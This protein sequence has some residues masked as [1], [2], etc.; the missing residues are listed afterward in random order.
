MLDVLL[1]QDSKSGISI[2]EYHEKDT[3]FNKDHS[4]IFS[5]FLMAIQS[6]TKELN[7]GTVVLIS[8]EGIRGHNCIIIPKSVINIILL[9]DQ[10]D[11]INVWRE[12]GNLIAER[13]LEMYGEDLKPY[14]ISMYKDFKKTIKE[15]CMGHKYCS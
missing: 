4:D 3:K 13:F 14:N 6:I 12:Q 7:I 15:L 8:T 2:L 11:P 10:E 5:G 1:I 9:V